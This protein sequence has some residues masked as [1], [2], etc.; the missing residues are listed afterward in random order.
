M[1]QRFYAPIPREFTNAGAVGSGWKLYF[2]TTLTT[3][4]ITTYSN[5]GLSSANT[6]PVVAD[7][8][9]RFAEIFVSDFSVVKAV[10]KDSSDNTIWTVDPVNPSGAS[11]VT[12]NDL[13][14]RPTSYWGVTAGTTSAYTLVANPT[15]TAYSNNHTFIFQAN[16]AN[17]DAPTLAIDGLAALNLKKYTGQGTKLA[18]QAGDMQATERYL[19]I[20]DGVDIVILNPRNSVIYAGSAAALTIA[21]GV[22][23]ATN[24]GSIYTIDTEG[25]AASDDLDTISGGVQG[26][27][28]VIGN[29]ADARNV[30]LK[31]NTGNI[32]NPVGLDITLD[33]TS[34]T[35]TLFF[36]SSLSK[37]LVVSAS[38]RNNFLFSK[39]TNSY[40]YLPNGVIMQWGSNT[41]AL[42]NGVP[43]TITLPLVFPTAIRSV[44]VTPNFSG[45][46]GGFQVNVLNKTTS[47]FQ[48]QVDGTSYAGGF[49][50]IA[51]GE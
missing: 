10:L 51:F 33:L 25:A 21:A 26:Q 31:H 1:A 32:F 3:T 38:V 41:T 29:T 44:V 49:N 13:G 15:I 28:I 50:W 35:A 23:T 42:N 48:A 2:Y 12:L 34:D 36:N 22:V 30:V 17:A 16:A 20:N 39:S 43:N 4:P 11:T 8:N 46:A 27:V 40:S 5:V 45:G 37:W 24:G 7:S 6:N 9:G 18:L 14:V 47:T 19:A